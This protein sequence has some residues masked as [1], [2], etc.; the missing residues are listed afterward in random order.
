MHALTAGLTGW[1]LGE[2]VRRKPLPALAAYP[3]AVVIHGAWNACAV[4]VGLAGIAAE[5]GGSQ[6]TEPPYVVVAAGGV[7]LLAA[8]TLGAV[9]AIPRIARR[10]MPRPVP[11]AA[12][13]EPP[14]L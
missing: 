7:V 6:L 10:L 1:A 14:A 11:A 9:V 3:A 4:A 2:A 8:L 12:A 5:A 13:P